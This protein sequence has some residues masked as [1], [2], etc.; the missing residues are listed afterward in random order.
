M[1]KRKL[2]VWVLTTALVCMLFSG[3]ATPAG[4]RSS[5]G[6]IHIKI[7]GTPLERTENNAAIYDLFHKNADAFMKENPNIV[8]EADSWSF[9]LQNYLAKGA[10]GDLPTMFTTSPTELKKLADT[11]YISDV[12]KLAKKYGYANAYDNE[13]Y[14]DQYMIDGKYYALI[15][16]SAISYIGVVYNNKVFKEAGLL[17]SDG[18]ID[19][20]QTWEELAETAKTIKDKTG[21]IGFVMPTKNNQGG[22]LFLNIMKAYGAD[23]ETE[24]DGK[25]K[26]VFASDEGVAALQ[27]IKDL[28]WKY[29]VLQD[30]II[31]DM[32]TA[33]QNIA[34]DNAAMTITGVGMLSAFVDKYELD[35]SKIEMSK[36]PAGPKGRYSQRNSTIVVFSGTEEE[37]EA[38][39]K[40]L[41]FIGQGVNV[42][43]EVK[44]NYEANVKIKNERNYPVGYGII[45]ALKNSK[46]TDMMNEIEKKYATVDSKNYEDYVKGEGVKYFSEPPRC[47]QQLYALF[48]AC[49]QQ[50]L[51]VKNA[52]CKAILEKA[53]KDFQ[54]NYLDKETN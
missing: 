52:D 13:L 50:V 20:P 25:W 35:T 27:Y 17:N 22:W 7:G 39:F 28:K 38:C 19:Y 48:D 16:D 32:Y 54:V 24:K 36:N 46:K 26:A 43:D 37:N 14:G 2:S 11:E 45:S 10:A 5:D 42:T 33:G 12:T 29:G 53:Q 41:D 18:K 3:C 31:A 23:F 30:E 15:Q 6:K 8:V 40:W 49:M 51:S 47:A 1:K 9:D 21:K 44:E 4:N 34:T